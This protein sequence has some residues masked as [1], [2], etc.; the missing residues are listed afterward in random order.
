MLVIA[1]TMMLSEGTLYGPMHSKQ[2]VA[3]YQAAVE[4]AKAQ[5]GTIQCG[6]KVSACRETN[7]VIFHK[8]ELNFYFPTMS[9][10]LKLCRCD[11]IL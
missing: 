7:W 9:L 1:L 8:S 4:D 11:R 10:E 2:G 6:G 5:G 3:A